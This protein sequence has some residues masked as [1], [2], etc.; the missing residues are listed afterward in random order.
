MRGQNVSVS[1]SHRLIT[2]FIYLGKVTVSRL[3]ENIVTET[4]L[5]TWEIFFGSCI[6][7]DLIQKDFLASEV[8]K[9]A[10]FVNLIFFFRLGGCE[11]VCRKCLLL[12]LNLSCIFSYKGPKCCERCDSCKIPARYIQSTLSHPCC[13]WK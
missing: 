10:N 8:A 13:D 11:T 4:F 1:N 9:F 5:L 7:F 2:F 12:F 3:L 6:V